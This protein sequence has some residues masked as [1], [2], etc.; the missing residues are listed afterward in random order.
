[1][2]LLHIKHLNISNIMCNIQLNPK[3][4]KHNNELKKNF[5]KSY[6]KQDSVLIKN[7]IIVKIIQWPNF[8]KMGLLLEWPLY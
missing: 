3:S 2:A 5:S 4:F 7:Q 6:H 8:T 1:M